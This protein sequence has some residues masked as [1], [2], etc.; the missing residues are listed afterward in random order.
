M[1]ST[2][3]LAGHVIG[4]IVNQDLTDETLERIVDEIKTKLEIHEK[5]NYTFST[6][7][8]NKI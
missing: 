4:L 8:R 2:F 5:V 3:D 1:L 6:F 7:K